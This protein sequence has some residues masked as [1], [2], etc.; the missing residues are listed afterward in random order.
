MY[1]FYLFG[2]W[3]VWDYCNV[4]EDV[5]LIFVFELGCFRIDVVI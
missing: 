1:I 4:V 3:F 2:V 5:E